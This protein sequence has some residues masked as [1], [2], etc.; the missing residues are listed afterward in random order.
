MFC[1]GFRGLG[2]FGFGSSGSIG[3]GGI[4]LASGFRLLILI[5][6]ILLA[7]KLFKSYSNKSN[8]SIRIIDEK[9]A[10][11]EISEEEYLKRRKII[12]SQR[13]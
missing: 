8:D 1:S 2:G 12:L 13:N 10:K 5:S 7:V 3:Y 6:L 4:F 11:G 9:F